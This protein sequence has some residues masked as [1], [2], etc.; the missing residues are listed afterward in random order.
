[1]T[2]IDT[3]ETD[4]SVYKDLWSSYNPDINKSNS[5]AWY[6]NRKIKDIQ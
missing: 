5:N 1:M 2:I 4:Y 3:Q 6:L